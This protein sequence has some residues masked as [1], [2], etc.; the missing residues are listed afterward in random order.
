MVAAIAIKF[1]LWNLKI[2]VLEGTEHWICERA[3][4]YLYGRYSG[5]ILYRPSYS[6]IVLGWVNPRWL[7]CPLPAAPTPLSKPLSARRLK[8]KIEPNAR[9]SLVTVFWV[10]GCASA[11]RSWRIRRVFVS[12]MPLTA[13][14]LS[15]ALA[16][17]SGESTVLLAWITYHVYVSRP[18][19]PTSPSSHTRSAKQTRVCHL[20]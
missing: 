4:H 19:V 9:R 20:Q 18:Q 7:R 5:N 15:L 6:S 12:F 17:V 10:L 11:A 1:P 2:K 3:V 8:V 16:S 13:R 14:P